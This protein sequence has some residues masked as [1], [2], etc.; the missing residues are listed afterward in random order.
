MIPHPT[1][2]IAL[3]NA[4]L[5]SRLREFDSACVCFPQCVVDGIVYN[6]GEM[7]Q[8]N[9]CTTCICQRGKPE[10]TRR[11]DVTNCVAPCQSSPCHNQGECHDNKLDVTGYQ[12]QCQ[13]PFEGPLCEVRQN[14]CVWPQ[15]QGFCNETVVKYYYDR[16]TEQCLAFNYSGNQTMLKSFDVFIG[17]GGNINNYPTLEACQE[18]AMTGACCFRRFKSEL[19]AIVEG[20]QE[21]ESKCQV[22]SLGECKRFHR[23]ENG[24]YTN[25]VIGFFPSLTCEEAGCV[26]PRQ[27]CF[28]D[29][30]VYQSGDTAL[31]GCQECTCQTD[32]QWS[33]GS[34][35]KRKEIRDMTVEEI[36]QFQSAVQQLR[37]TGPGNVW[38]RFPRIEQKLQE[39]DCSITIPYF[40]FTTDVGNFADAIIWQPNYFGGDGVSGCVPDHPFG[41]AG[42]WRPC[43]AR[44]FNE[45]IE[46]PSLAELALALAS[47]D[48][49][50]MS[51][52]LETYIGYL[53][54]YIGGDM[55]TT[56]GPHD[57]TCFIG[58]GRNELTI[59]LD[60]LVHLENIMMVPFDVPPS[61]VLD[62]ENDLCVTYIL[63]SKGHP[64][65]VSSSDSSEPDRGDIPI[66][67]ENPRRW[68]GYDEDGFDRRGF[69][70]RDIKEMLIGFCV[71][72]FTGF[73]RD[74]FDKYGYD[75]QGYD[76]YGFNRSGYNRY[77]FDRYGL[78]IAGQT[79]T[80]NRYGEDG[81]DKFCLNNQ[82]LT[83]DGYDRFGFTYD[84][85]DVNHCNYLY[86][87]PF[88]SR[89][90]VKIWDILSVQS[91][92]YLMSIQ[93]TCPVLDIVPTS[94]I[95]QF[96]MS[97]IKDVQVNLVTAKVPVPPISLPMERFCFD[98]SS[99]LSPCS[100]DTSLT[101]CSDNPC[102]REMCP[103]YPDAVCHVDFCTSCKANWYYNG[104]LV[105]CYAERD[106]CDPNP[107]EN[108]GT[109]VESI[110]PTE[111]QLV[112]CQCP[113]GF[114][115]HLCQVRAVEV[116]SLPRSTGLTTS[117]CIQSYH[118]IASALHH[119]IIDYS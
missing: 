46:L 49:T 80:S 41:P 22:I 85:Y 82:G 104:V 38:E 63:P 116:C 26:R 50:E 67:P 64:C 30:T 77:G 69:M 44:N 5:K 90:S 98:T 113:P 11:T 56:G 108:G 20:D 27:G 17:C 43:I 39:I 101:S 78:D 88:A 111:P 94:W 59:N 40:D 79:D 91:K 75:R 68:Q 25:E 81:F 4:D 65:N 96:W 107:C 105:D 45:S 86:H 34:F 51:M 29:D 87:G 100:C 57:P 3:H 42:S 95:T 48:Y 1:E 97:E 8:T 6:D 13:P 7:W 55:A 89:Q 115:G 118:L 114:D 53:H 73:N 106:F 15:E 32:G 28:Y 2:I 84:G 99:Y 58:D 18:V 31:Q 109:C 62:L 35:I 110:W 74:G 112:T 66:S 92:P 24:G 83:S 60:T 33:C 16:F 119:I 102:L 47:E 61:S 37:L 14:P 19:D 76:R 10:C 117:T 93:R 36:T 21:E 54:R 71:L 9:F 70:K 23:Q 72:W 12:C 52:C 103:S